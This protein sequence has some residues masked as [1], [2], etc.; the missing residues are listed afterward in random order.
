VFIV[1]LQNSLHALFIFA[2][3]GSDMLLVAVS[4]LRSLF[5]KIVVVKSTK[6]CIEIDSKKEP[7]RD[8]MFQKAAG[9]LTD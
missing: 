2:L 6:S 1:L 5:H 9:K 8:V 4:V 7:R 3:Y